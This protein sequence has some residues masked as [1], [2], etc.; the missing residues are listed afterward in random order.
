MSE[1]DKRAAAVGCVIRRSRRANGQYDHNLLL[2]S[3]DTSDVYVEAWARTKAGLE[4]H[5]ASLET[6]KAR[7]EQG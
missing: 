2:E 3:D 6:A 5:I 7:G 4:P 1:L